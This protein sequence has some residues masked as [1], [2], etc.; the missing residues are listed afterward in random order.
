MSGT[1]GPESTPASVIV[2]TASRRG[3]HFGGGATA[4]E[5]EVY[6]VDEATLARLDDFEDHPGF[7]VRTWIGVEGGA[8]VEAYVLGAERAEGWPVIASGDWRS[9]YLAQRS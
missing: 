4:I 2:D 8:R 1:S 9:P 7:Y 5:G 3:R 6:E